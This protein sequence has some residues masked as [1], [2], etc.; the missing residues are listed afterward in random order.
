M[1]QAHS[2]QIIP[3]PHRHTATAGA[4]PDATAQIAPDV[5]LPDPDRLTRA[6]AALL[7]AQQEQKA[8]LQRWQAA[9]A[10][11]QSGVRGLG[12]SLAGCSDAL[13]AISPPSP[14]G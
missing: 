8:A 9:I 4:A 3:F 1:A 6:L 13:K 12:Q 7:V 14:R 2:A 10:D 11:L 5:A